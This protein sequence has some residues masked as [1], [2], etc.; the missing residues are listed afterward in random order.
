MAKDMIMNNANKILEDMLKAFDGYDGSME[1]GIEIIECNQQSMDKLKDLFLT[2]ES[3]WAEEYQN[4]LETVMVK[5]SELLKILH[6]EKEFL[7]EKIE[8][9]NKRKKVVNNYMSPN[10]KSIFVDKEM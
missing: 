10:I 5:Q 4:K 2:D 7:F 6:K 8:Q 9:M 3:I 1:S